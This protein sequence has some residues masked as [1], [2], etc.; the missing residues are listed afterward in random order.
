VIGA[1]TVLCGTINTLLRLCVVPSVS[2]TDFPMADCTTCTS[3]LQRLSVPFLNN[4]AS[5]IL[6]LSPGFKSVT[7]LFYCAL[8]IFK[9]MTC[10]RFLGSDIAWLGVILSSAATLRV[11]YCCIVQ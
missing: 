6:T 5:S 2:V 7:N 4:D 1:I 9:C 11:V 3:S 8:T 10:S